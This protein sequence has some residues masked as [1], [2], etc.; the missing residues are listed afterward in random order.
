MI[1]INLLPKELIRKKVEIPEVP[2][3]PIIGTFLGVIIAAH[4]SIGLAVSLKSKSLRKL[5]KRLDGILPE[6]KN[7]DEVI[8]ELT[9][10]RT[11]IDAIDSLIQT[12]MS[13]ARKLSDLSDAMTQGVWLKKLWL[14]KK[15][16][17]RKE[18][19]EAS[20]PKQI[21]VK[22]LHLNGSV[23]TAGGDEAAVIG[24]FIRSLKKN[25]G[26]FSDFNEVESVSIQ[27]NRLE[28]VEIMD[29]ELICHFK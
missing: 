1:E 17:L 5:E 22:I 23:I 8:R 16:E 21:L 2:F 19:E 11:K 28:E 18:S 27:R 25:E 10:M 9:S 4:L 15:M 12:R 24:K 29:F 7:A 6:K 13:W 20:E 14:E 26:F 3:I